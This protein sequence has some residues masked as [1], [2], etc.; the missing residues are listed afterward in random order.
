MTV[1]AV[2]RGKKSTHNAM[3]V[4]TV[5]ASSDRPE[6]WTDKLSLIFEDTY[7]TAV[8]EPNIIDVLRDIVDFVEPKRPHLLDP[9]TIESILSL[10]E[11]LWL[12]REMDAQPPHH[13]KG[14]VLFVCT[15]GEVFFWL[16]ETDEQGR[17]FIRPST[18]TRLEEGECIV[19]WGSDRYDVKGLPSIDREALISAIERVDREAR[20]AG[21]RGLAYPLQP[22]FSSVL[23]PHDPG[24]AAQRVR[25]FSLPE[26]IV[27]RTW[28]D[29]LAVLEK[30]DFVDYGL[31]PAS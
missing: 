11:R 8:G 30:P 15:R 6:S 14:S 24:L 10:V 1:V 20:A 16:L 21:K 3:V 4:D 2:Y 13:S 29:L 23:V 7:V 9:R 5:C 28:P 12:L 19:F 26:L 18:P 25:P 31:P 17:R 22:P 27:R